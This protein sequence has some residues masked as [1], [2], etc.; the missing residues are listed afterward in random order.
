METYR[1]TASALLRL[2]AIASQAPGVDADEVLGLLQEA[3][4]I[5]PVTSD[6]SEPTIGDEEARPVKPAKPE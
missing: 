2:A 1:L 5:T 4:P 3:V 6:T